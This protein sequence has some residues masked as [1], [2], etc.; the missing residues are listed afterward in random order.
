MIT[1]IPQVSIEQT[2][3]LFNSNNKKD[4]KKSLAYLKALNATTRKKERKLNITENN[5]WM[6]TEYLYRE[7]KIAYKQTYSHC[8]PARSKSTEN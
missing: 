3:F 2:F 4:N 8:T 1:K 5:P 6:S 7:D